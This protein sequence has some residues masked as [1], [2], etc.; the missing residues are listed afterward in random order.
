M[1]SISSLYKIFSNY[2]F[3]WLLTSCLGAAE[4]QQN[5]ASIAILNDKEIGID[6][7]QISNGGTIEIEASEGWL[8]F[9]FHLSQIE[10]SAVPEASSSTT[11]P[12]LEE[13]ENH[14]NKLGD[15]YHIRGIRIG[16]CHSDRKFFDV[17]S[18]SSD[19]FQVNSGE[20]YRF[21]PSPQNIS[22]NVTESATLDDGE[23]MT[24]YEMTLLGYLYLYNSTANCILDRQLPHTTMDD[25]IP[26]R[27]F[28]NKNSLYH[29]TFLSI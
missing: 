15:V 13:N 10:C 12:L 26:F 5:L 27:N 4:A 28:G 14:N 29:N 2:I 8:Y 22:I 24:G 16:D 19:G 23:L 17:F 21:I 3:C 11:P 20:A 1:I 9:E 18:Y 7:S 25:K 6:I